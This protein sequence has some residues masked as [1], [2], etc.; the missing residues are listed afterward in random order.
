MRLAA[1]P[2]LLAFAPPLVAGDKPAPL[3]ADWHGT[4]TGKLV[5]TSPADLTTEV[6]VALAVEPIRG[7]DEVTWAVTYG[8]GGKKVEKGY[9]LVPVAGKPGRFRIDERNGIVLDARLVGGVLYSH[10][11]VGGNWLTARYELRDGAIR[12]EVTS[13]KP[14]AEKTGDGKVQ[15]YPVESVQAAELKRK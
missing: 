1:L 11:E 14:A 8:E 10:F 15:G 7:T 3:P 4:W 13:A 2:L 5:I 6:P 9:K 12:F